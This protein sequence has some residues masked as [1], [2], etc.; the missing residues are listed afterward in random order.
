MQ[1]IIRIQLFDK[2]LQAIL[3]DHPDKV[4]L[5]AD[6]L[7]QHE[8]A[9]ENMMVSYYFLDRKRVYDVTIDKTTVEINRDG[10]GHFRIN[11]ML[12]LFNAC[13]DV[14]ASDLTYMDILMAV[15]FE[16]RN[17]IL[18]GEDIPEREPDGL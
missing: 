17:M 14:D 9:I 1:E 4:K 11:Y 15:D 3:A 12:G 8:K 7:D 5:I 2:T 6:E 10:N 13:A 18:T 16:K